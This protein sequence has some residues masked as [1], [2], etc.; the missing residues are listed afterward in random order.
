MFKI[1]TESKKICYVCLDQFTQF[2]DFVVK[3]K[4]LERL[5]TGLK[6]ENDVDLIP[7]RL[8]A[9][10]AHFNLK[11]VIP[12]TTSDDS[13]NQPDVDYEC[14]E[15]RID[16]MEYKEEDGIL[17]DTLDEADSSTIVQE[18]FVVDDEIFIEEEVEDTILEDYLQQPQQRLSIKSRNLITEKTEDEKLFTFSCHICSQEFLKMK[19]LALHCKE[20]HNCQPLVRCC[21]QDCDAVLSTWRR[22]MIH[23][24]NHFPS[25]ENLRCPECQRVYVTLP[26]FKKHMEK[27][28]IRYVCSHCGKVFKETKTLQWHEQTHLK[29]LD[30]RRN[31]QCSNAEC[32][33]KF[34]TKQ[35]CE[36]HFRMK[37]ERIINCYCKYPDCNKGFF[38]KKA[39]YE[40]MRNTHTD[41]KFSC[42][43]CSFKAKTKSALNTHKDIHQLGEEYSCDLCDA[44][45]SVYR[46]LKAHMGEFSFF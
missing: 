41:R 26:G 29:S 9:Y 45:F 2:H 44:A 27:H 46:R 31:H 6:E 43:L 15:Y 42:E 1:S 21:S 19:L 11:S 12:E 24:E 14:I 13:N 39:Y 23:K 40:H 30:D 7:K 4:S 25:D 37:H 3:A 28:N 20:Q 33:R 36:N 17:T 34:I 35:A 22:L 38:T 5:F 32:G 10:R 8:N 16:D 18:E